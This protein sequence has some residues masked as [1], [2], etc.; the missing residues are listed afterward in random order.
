MS[1]LFDSLFNSVAYGHLIVDVLNSQR[2]ILLAYWSTELQW[3]ETHLAFLTML[4][5]WAASLSQPIFGWIS[6]KC[7]KSHWI[8]A[9]GY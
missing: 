2:A 7:G 9:G 3:S 4:Y 8:T 6:D 5:I 1:I